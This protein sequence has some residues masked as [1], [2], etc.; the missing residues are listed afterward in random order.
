MMNEKRFSPA[1]EKI[2]R[3]GGWREGRDVPLSS[4]SLSCE[5]QIFPEAEKILREF[6]GLS[7][8]V[9][10]R[11]IDTWTQKITV[12]PR[13][14]DL[15]YSNISSFKD[16]YPIGSR[17]R[18]NVFIYVDRDGMIYEYSIQASDDLECIKFT[19][20]EAI[21]KMLLGRK[22]WAS[23]TAVDHQK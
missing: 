18:G 8:G 15:G 19:F 10:G 11:G 23:D 5:Y 12:D 14:G 1:V 17:D 21:E 20:Y 6:G 2:L 9:A 22:W 16:V 7:F 3:A 13:S 4:L